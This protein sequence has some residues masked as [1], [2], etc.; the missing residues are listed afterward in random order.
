MLSQMQETEERLFRDISRLKAQLPK[1]R[2]MKATSTQTDLKNE[3]QQPSTTALHS[4]KIDTQSRNR[5]TQTEEC[6]EIEILPN[7]SYSKAFEN[8]SSITTRNHKIIDNTFDDIRCSLREFHALHDDITEMGGVIKSVFLIVN[9]PTTQ[10]YTRNT[11]DVVK[12][13]QAELNI[14]DEKSHFTHTT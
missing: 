11:Y 4:T 10:E 6:S 1:L 8:L 12:K 7:N 5:K 14:P 13:I 9:D 2:V 3:Q